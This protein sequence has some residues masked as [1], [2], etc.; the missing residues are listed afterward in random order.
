LIEVSVLIDA[1]INKKGLLLLG[2]GALDEIV[3]D[4]VVTLPLR[5]RYYSALLQQIADDEGTADVKLTFAI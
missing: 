5:N 2:R 3:E 4:V 1:V